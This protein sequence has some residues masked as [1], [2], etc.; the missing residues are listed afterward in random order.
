[1]KYLRAFF[2]VA[3]CASAAMPAWAVLE[4]EPNVT[5]KTGVASEEAGCTWEQGLASAVVQRAEGAVVAPA[6]DAPPAAGQKLSLQVIRFETTRYEKKSQYLVGVRADVSEGGKLVATRDF[7]SHDSFR[8]DKGGCEELKSIGNSIAKEAG[9]WLAKAKFIECGEGCAGI[10]AD[11]AIVV[12]TELPILKPESVSDAIRSECRFPARL[13]ET[14]VKD[15]NKINYPPQR[16]QLEPRAIDDTFTGRRL[17]L[18]IQDMRALGGGPWTGTKYLEMTGEL[19]DGALL[20]GN[21]TVHVDANSWGFGMPTG[22][23]G[24]VAGLSDSATKLIVQ[25][26]RGPTLNARLR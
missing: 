9:K 5:Y 23:C 22:T 8:N 21:F 3:F 19:R 13:V 1:M 4:L 14:L 20:V 16:V 18:R 2:T 17:L 6:A 7:Q 26:L 24:S 12:N 11:E 25:W 10:H 15:Y